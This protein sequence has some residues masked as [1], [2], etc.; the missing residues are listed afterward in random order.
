MKIYISGKITGFTFEEAKKRFSL[1]EKQITD[2]GHVAVNPIKLN[3]DH[4]QEWTSFMRVD[5]A[6][7]VTCDA[8][9]LQ[10]NWSV[11]KGACIEHNL[12]QQLGIPC[13][14]EHCTSPSGIP[15]LKTAE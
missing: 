11:S 6:E 10:K 2:A 13:Y 12:A 7:L 14:F 9:F 1:V 3:H 4:D 15:H 8:L 5:I